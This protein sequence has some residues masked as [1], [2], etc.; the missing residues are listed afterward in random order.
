M[1]V[2]PLMSRI[3]VSHP[4]RTTGKIIVLYV[5]SFTCLDSEREDKRFRTEWY[6]ALLKFSICLHN[7]TISYFL[8]Y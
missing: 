7:I 3:Q 5:V 8:F 1:Y 6:Q 2:R 4:Y